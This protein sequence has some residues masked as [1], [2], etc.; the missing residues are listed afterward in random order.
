MEDATMKKTYQIPTIEVVRMEMHQM[1]AASDQVGFGSSVD[2]ATG[3]ESREYNGL[4][5]TIDED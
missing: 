2:S 3:A 5:W 1:L 4:F